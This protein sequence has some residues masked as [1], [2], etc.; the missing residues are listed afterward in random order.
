MAPTKATLYYFPL[1]GRAEVIKLALAAKNV[2]FDV[3]PVDYAAMKSDLKAYHFGQCPRYADAEADI[4][5]SNAILR[6]I[7]RKYNMYGASLGEAALV[8]EFLDGVESLRCKYLELIY[9]KQ[10]SPEGKAEYIK[11]H[12]A[13]ESAAERNGGAHF[14]YLA[15]ILAANSGQYVVGSDLTIADLALFDIVDL[16]LRIMEEE[17]TAKYP[18]LV[19]HKNCIASIPAIKAYLEGPMRLEK[20]N[21]NGL[22]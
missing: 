1:R 6:H 14:V 16:H 15:G 7:G 17:I 10:L 2:D 5:Q 3:Q 9:Q 18:A 4:C 19:E 12:V 21:G 8:D 20:V 13:M 22:G 11:A